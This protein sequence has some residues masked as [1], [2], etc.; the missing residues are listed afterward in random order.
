MVYTKPH[1]NFKIQETNQQ[2]I[3]NKKHGEMT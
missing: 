3:G 1:C 2:I